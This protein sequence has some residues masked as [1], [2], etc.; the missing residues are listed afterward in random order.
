MEDRMVETGWIENG[1]PPPSH[2]TSL[3]AESGS[4]IFKQRLS[5]ETGLFAASVSRDQLTI[6]QQ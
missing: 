3:E 5:D 6:N 1:C 2:R 4:G